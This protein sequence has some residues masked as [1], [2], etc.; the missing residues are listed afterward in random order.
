VAPGEA[1]GMVGVGALGALTIV[2]AR[3][4]SPAAIV[5]YGMRAAELE[6]ARRLG[7]TEAHTVSG[8]A[9]PHAGEL[10]LVVETA[11]AVPAVE[12]ATRLPREGRPHRPSGSSGAGFAGA[13]AGY[14][15]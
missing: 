14:E 5:A 11:G 2:L 1:I 8:T 9:A 6:L 4:F 13:G 12:L 3:L 15:P 10:D 7:A